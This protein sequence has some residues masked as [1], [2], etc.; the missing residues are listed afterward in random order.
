MLGSHARCSH[1]GARIPEA[2]PMRSA[3]VWPHAPPASGQGRTVSPAHATVLLT[4]TVP[5]RFHGAKHSM[6]H[7]CFTWLHPSLASGAILFSCTLY[8]CASPQQCA[9]LARLPPLACL[10]QRVSNWQAPSALR[11]P[12]CARFRSVCNLMDL[13]LSL[14]QS[15]G[16]NPNRVE[17]GPARPILLHSAHGSPATAGLR[18]GASADD[19]AKRQP[20]SPRH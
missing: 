17:D 4:C 12:A 1:V 10:F 13:A 18:N 14:L 5:S 19:G 2:E 16:S 9:T 15:E 8:G 20:A 11:A 3:T 7:M 6:A